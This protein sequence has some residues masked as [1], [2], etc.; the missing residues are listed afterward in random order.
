ME[1]RFGSLRRVCGSRKISHVRNLTPYWH[2]AEIAKAQHAFFN[3]LDGF[4]LADL[5][6]PVWGD[7]AKIVR[8]LSGIVASNFALQIP[9]CVQQLTNVLKNPL[10]DAPVWANS[11]QV[12]LQG[13]HK[14]LSTDIRPHEVIFSYA[15]LLAEL[16]LYTQA[17]IALQITVEAAIAGDNSGDYQWWQ[18]YGR[19]LL[20]DCKRKLT[21]KTAEDLFRL[22]GVRNQIAH[23][24]AKNAF[25]G[26]GFP[27]PEN[28]PNIIKRITPAVRELLD[29][30]VN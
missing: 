22:E 2:F 7:G 10:V 5:L 1:Q 6:D 4:K 29:S 19:G 13:L 14:R 15:Q 28:I 17:V 9:E 20:S 24:G 12:F 8:R 30:C 27:N 3:Q 21:K 18:E 23:G 16:K 25:G 26:K 11:V